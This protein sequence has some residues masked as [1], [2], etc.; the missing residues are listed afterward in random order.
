MKDRHIET[1]TVA[2]ILLLIALFILGGC[3]TVEKVI[4]RNDTIRSTVIRERLRDTIITV[5]GDSSAVSYL[6]E[7]QND[8]AKLVE[9]I[10]TSMGARTAPPKVEIKD[11][12]LTAKCNVDSMAIYMSWK[13]R[14]TTKV[15]SITVAPEPIRENYLTGWQWFQVWTGRILAAVAVLFVGIWWIRRKRPP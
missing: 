4:V 3:R 1:A 13:E 12:I 14:D 6:I 8:K 7:C 11:R 15:T 10:S 9:L 5:M 2:A